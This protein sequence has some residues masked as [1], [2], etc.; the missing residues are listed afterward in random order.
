MGLLDVIADVMLELGLQGLINWVE[1]H[2]LLAAI[3]GA[4]M[5]VAA[6]LILLV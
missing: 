6:L 2:K 4:L 3:I 5:V 1:D